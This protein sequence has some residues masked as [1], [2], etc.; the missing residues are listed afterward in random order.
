MEKLQASIQQA[1][2][3]IEEEKQKNIELLNLIFPSDIAEKLWN[4]K[5]SRIYILNQIKTKHS[6]IGGPYKL[7]H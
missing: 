6:I 3:E 2:E 1:Y 7:F 5:D 4:G